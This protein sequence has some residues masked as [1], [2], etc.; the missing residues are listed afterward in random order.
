M[1][2]E[3][4][5]M[6]SGWPALDEYALPLIGTE[7][8]SVLEEYLL[9]S[10]NSGGTVCSLH[11]A[12]WTPVQPETDDGYDT[13]YSDQTEL[14]D[15]ARLLIEEAQRLMSTMDSQSAW[16]ISIMNAAADLEFLIYSNASSDALNNAMNV[17]T[18]TM[19]GIY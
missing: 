6:V 15:R 10:E 17:L 3:R 7:Y 14:K 8:Q 1:E 12:G 4:K 13:R 16:C 9:L 19:M 5:W 11:G 2:I 18:Q